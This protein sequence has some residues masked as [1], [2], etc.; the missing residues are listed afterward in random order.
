MWRHMATDDVTSVVQQILLQAKLKCIPMSMS[1]I[2]IGIHGVISFILARIIH[3]KPDIIHFE[4]RTFYTVPIP[5]D[6]E[7]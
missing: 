2:I 3:S 4:L 5:L 6:I 1:I 7:L